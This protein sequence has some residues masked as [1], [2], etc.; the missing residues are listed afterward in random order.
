M[1]QKRWKDETCEE[2]C[3]DF[4]FDHSQ[5]KL[6]FLQNVNEKRHL[7]KPAEGNSMFM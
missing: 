6:V 1:T 4:A 5:F 7:I 3:C 2:F